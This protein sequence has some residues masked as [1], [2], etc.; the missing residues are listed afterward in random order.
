MDSAIRMIFH[1]IVIA[2]V[3]YVLMRFLLQ[4]RQAVAESRSV[5]I[6]ALA[7]AYMVLFGHGMPRGINRDIMG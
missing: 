6:G 4:Q 7:L 3:L 1:A 5:L 2:V